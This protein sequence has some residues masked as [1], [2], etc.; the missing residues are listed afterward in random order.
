[1]FVY[2]H[3]LYTE[4]TERL[5]MLTIMIEQKNV[6]LVVLNS[7]DFA[8]QNSRQRLAIVHWARKMRDDLGVSIAIYMLHRPSDFGAMGQLALLADSIKET[9]E[10][11]HTQPSEFP[12]HITINTTLALQEI[13][14]ELK[15]ETIPT[16]KSAN[17]PLIYND[18]E[19]LTAR[20]EVEVGEEEMEYA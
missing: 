14:E 12:D 2:Q 3:K 13:I 5:K 11:R 6:R 7:F 10:W 1:M 20:E 19:V 4:L 15:A 18:L 8:T 17:T 16:P 9:A